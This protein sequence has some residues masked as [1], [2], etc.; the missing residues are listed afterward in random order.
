MTDAIIMI[1]EIICFV[2]LLFIL[3]VKNR[4]VQTKLLKSICAIQVI[5]LVF[6]IIK[7]CSLIIKK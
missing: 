2:G 5:A 4:D 6:V 1:L 7:L 3:V